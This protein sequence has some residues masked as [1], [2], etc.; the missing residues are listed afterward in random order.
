M[1][2]SL[3]KEAKVYRGKFKRI[4]FGDQEILGTGTFKIAHS[5]PLSAGES[6]QIMA[7]REQ[8]TIQ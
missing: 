8:K 4:M 1:D 6:D 7:E 2:A 3:I 5:I